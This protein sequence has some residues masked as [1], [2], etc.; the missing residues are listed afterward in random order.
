MIIFQEALVTLILEHRDVR[1]KQPEILVEEITGR[2][3]IKQN[4]HYIMA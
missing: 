3:T 2:R 4:Y 1:P